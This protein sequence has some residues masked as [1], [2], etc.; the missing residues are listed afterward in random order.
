M[1]HRRAFNKLGRNSSHRRAMIRNM[2][3]S[4]FE[5]EMITTTLA[6]AKASRRFAEKMI[7]LGK[8]GTLHAR[9]KALEF[10]QTKKIVHKL[11]EELAP[12]YEERNGGYTRII[13]LGYRRGDAAKMCVLEL[14]DRG[15]EVVKVDKKPKDIIQEEEPEVKEETSEEDETSEEKIE[16]TEENTSDD[17]IN[18]N[19]EKTEEDETPKNEE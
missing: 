10:I 8:K 14:V 7:T 1:R 9:R 11:F 15:K 13:H 6:K 5:H 17:E 19:P 2:V 4:L 16:E 12:R 18:E 3:T